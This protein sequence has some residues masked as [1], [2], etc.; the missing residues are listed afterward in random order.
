MFFQKFYDYQKEK[1]AKTNKKVALFSLITGA[2][3][4]AAG[5][6]SNKENRENAKKMAQDAASQAQDLGSKAAEKAKDFGNTAGSKFNEIKQ[7]AGEKLDQIEDKI[8]EMVNKNNEEE[9][10][11]VPVKEDGSKKEETNKTKK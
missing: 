11:L 10:E 1:E 7:K 9:I 8:D 6:L 2:V 4:L 3:G 5:Y